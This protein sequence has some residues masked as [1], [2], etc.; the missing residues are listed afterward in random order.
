MSR[1]FAAIYDR[2]L[3]STEEAGLREERARL[4]A[5]ASGVVVELGA[6]TGLNLD[7]YDRD[8][9]TRLVLTE[10]DPHMAKRLRE[11]AAGTDAEVHEAP[12]E[13]LPLEDGSADTVVSTLVLCT[14]PD[15]EAVLREVARV[16][17]PG[18]RLLAYEHVRSDEAGTAKWQDRLERPWGWVAGGCHPNRDTLSLIKGSGLQVVESAPRHLPKA[19]PIVRPALFAVAERTA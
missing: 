5:Q 12:A 13:R 10:P 7:H 15:P 14:V 11:R 4:V 17:R 2:M 8:A 16:L 1:F 18:G 9:V 3:A 6:G 19:P